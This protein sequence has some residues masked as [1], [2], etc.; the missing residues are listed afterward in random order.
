MDRSL[1]QK[2]LM[3]ATG[4]CLLVVS[5]LAIGAPIYLSPEDADIVHDTDEPGASPTLHADDVQDLFKTPTTLKLLYKAEHK[6]NEEGIF[7]SSYT[8]DFTGA[9]ND[10]LIS[11]I[12]GDYILCPECYLVV[13]DGNQPQYLFNLGEWSGQSEL[14]LQNFYPDQGAISHVAIFGA[15]KDV[16]VP[17]PTTA[18]LLATGVFGLF[19]SRR[20]M[21]KN[22]VIN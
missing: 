1:I 12:G 21:R 11:Y 10:A 7:A 17:E 6:G 4:A 16:P 13:K 8:T 15:Y 18:L 2:T 9:P 20:R 19:A 5:Q 14:S 22:H 3:A